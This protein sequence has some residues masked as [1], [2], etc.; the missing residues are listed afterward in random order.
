MPAASIHRF[1]RGRVHRDEWSSS[2]RPSEP[3]SPASRK[4]ITRIRWATR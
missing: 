2:R 1:R 4:T 3:L